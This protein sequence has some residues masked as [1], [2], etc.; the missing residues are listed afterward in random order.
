MGINILGYGNRT[1]AYSNTP[2]N[3]VSGQGYVLPSGQYQLWP[4][5]YTFL[6]YLDPIT[7]MWRTLATPAQSDSQVITSDG[8]NYRLYNATGTMVGAVI[9]NAGTGY[10]NGIYPPSAQ[11]GTAAAP[12]VTMSA[13]GGTI[14]AKPTLIVGGAINTT[15]TITAGGSGYTVAPILVVS[16]PPQGGVPATMTCTISGGA[17]NAVTVTNQGAGYLTAPTVTVVNGSGDVTGSG[18][19]LTVN[20]TLVGSGTVTAIIIQGNVPYT[21][22]SVSQNG[23]F[24]T[25]NLTGGTGGAG[26]TSV[27]TFTFAPASTTAATSVMCFTVTT[28]NAQT[29]MTNSTGNIGFLGSAVT[30]GSA[31]LTNPAISTGA[32]LPRVG[33]TAW[34]TT[35]TGGT[36]IVD[37]G[38]HQTVVAGIAYANI[39][40]GTV[41]GATSAVAA[42]MGG[43]TDLSYIQQI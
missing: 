9:T 10:T 21:T 31:T 14:V 13:A 20:P 34:S 7:L 2:I 35:A 32:F 18:G 36:A 26:M 28:A 17:I 6:Q 3:L 5:Q 39:G 19:V 40:N 8:T 11:L 43:A 38:L 1:P 42:T 29:G 37:G 15:V 33:Y 30:A 41:S 12:S 24:P 25:T 22:A 4:G 23:V 27:P 16:A